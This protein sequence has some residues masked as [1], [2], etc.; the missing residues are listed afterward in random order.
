MQCVLCNCSIRVT[1][2]LGELMISLCTTKITYVMIKYRESVQPSI[3]FMTMMSRYKMASAIRGTL[4]V[5]PY[6]SIGVV[7]LVCR[8]LSVHKF[9]T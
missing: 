4:I 8:V 3:S 2:I 9:S 7:A 1:A 6:F 5:S